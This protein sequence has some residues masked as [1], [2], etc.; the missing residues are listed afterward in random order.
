MT[1]GKRLEPRIGVF[2]PDVRDAYGRVWRYV[3]DGRYRSATHTGGMV[4]PL[5]LVG[6]VKELDK[7]EWT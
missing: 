2:V 7:G 3:G 4:R 1:R 6:A 5:F